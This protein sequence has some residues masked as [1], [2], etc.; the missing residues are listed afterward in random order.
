MVNS[1]IEGN[2]GVNVDGYNDYRGVPVM[3]A[4]TWLDKL[5]LGL[6]TEIDVSEALKLFY[7]IRLSALIGVSIALL[8]IIGSILF[9]LS[10]GE[11]ANVALIIAKDELEDRVKLRTTQLNNEKGLLNS[12]INAIPDL[13]FFKDTNFKFLGANKAFEKQ[14]GFKKEEFIGKKDD[15]F[16]PEELSKEFEKTDA[17]IIN[18]SKAISMESEDIDP[19]GNKIVY[20]TKK[21]PFHNEAGELLGLIGVSRDITIKKK[22]EEEILKRTQELNDERVFLN[23]LINNIPDEIF[24]KDINYN[25]LGANESFLKAIDKKIN[26]IIGKSDFALLPTKEAKAFKKVNDKVLKSLKTITTEHE[27]ISIHG[28]N[29]TQETRKTPF[30]NKKGDLIG[31]IG[32]SRDITE[33]KKAE[34]RL[35]SQSAALK[36]TANGVVITNAKG[37][38]VW[39]NPAFRKLTGYSWEELIGE[40]PRILNSGKHDKAFL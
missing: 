36:S 37:E 19:D 16:V 6:A 14:V 13:I 18:E 33:R 4:W 1:A 30:F 3:G 7:F 12:L 2:N 35:K 22:A 28:N 24:Y 15:H 20:D 31:L 25:Y 27:T 34:I 26:E 32:I 23:T 11:K 29:I 17:I 39:V 21:S 8:L 40:N 5:E 38:I 9:T 10:L